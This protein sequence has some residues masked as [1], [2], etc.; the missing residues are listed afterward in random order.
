MERPVVI[1][2]AS[3]TPQGGFQGGLSAK[4]APGLL[5]TLV[6]GPR[7]WVAGFRSEV[8]QFEQS[9]QRTEVIGGTLVVTSQCPEAECAVDHWVVVPS[10][11]VVEV[12]TDVGD[13]WVEG[14]SG[15]VFADTSAG[16]LDLVDLTGPIDVTAALGDVFGTGLG[17]GPLTVN[18]P[19]GNIA[20]SLLG[21]VTELGLQTSSGDV[22]VDVP[23][24]PYD[25]RVWSLS[26]AVELDGV[27][28]EQDAEGLIVASTRSGD[29][30]IRG[31]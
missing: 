25:I 21:A 7:T 8:E 24:G 10:G 15:G 27:V 5:A 17:G 18:A 16:V 12:F 31:Y 4:S 13:V 20:V 14:I 1:A 6:D 3:R 30:R 19:D 11:A 28:D 29:V 22:V 23:S 2:G 9:L 26:G